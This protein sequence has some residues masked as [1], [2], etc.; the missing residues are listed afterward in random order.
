MEILAFIPPILIG[1]AIVVMICPKFSLKGAWAVLTVCLGSGIG[2]GITSATIFLWLA[3]FG[4]PGAA[5]LVFEV[6]SAILLTIIAFYRYHN[7]KSGSQ[8]ESTSDCATNDVPIKWLKRLFIILLIISSGS[9][10]LKTFIG[11]S[12]RYN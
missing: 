11:R 1:T 10:G 12:I 5:Y 4:R 9:F 6:G 7:N 3:W 8:N 2:L